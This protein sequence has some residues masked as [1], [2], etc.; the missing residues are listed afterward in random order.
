MSVFSILRKM[1]ECCIKIKKIT[2]IVHYQC[3]IYSKLKMKRT[4]EDVIMVY[5]RIFHSFNSVGNQ[6]PSSEEIVVSK[7]VIGR[8]ISKNSRLCK[9]QLP[10]RVCHKIPFINS[11]IHW[12]RA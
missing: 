4:E 9:N 3:K 6:K 12:K 7:M 2:R 10:P 1:N 8:V 5:Y 11:Q